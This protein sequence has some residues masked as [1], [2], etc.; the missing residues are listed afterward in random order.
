MNRA[1][2]L[3]TGLVLT[4]VAGY[5][6][7]IGFVRL[8]GLY[9]SFMSGNTTQ[10]SVLLGHGRP[11]HALL[12]VLLVLAFLTGA[13][14][15]SGLAILVPKRWATPAV[16]AYEALLILGALAL[17][18]ATPELELAAIFMALAMGTQNAVLGQV[19][20]FRAGTTFV[21][22]ALFSLGQKIAQALT[23][24]GRPLGWVGDAAVWLALLVGALAGTVA[25]GALDLYALTIPAAVAGLFAAVAG[26]LSARGG[27]GAL[28]PPAAPS[29]SPKVPSA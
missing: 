1:W 23:G 24:T 16:L 21:T 5:V 6:D 12:P 17:G 19:Q 8:G 9:T 14:L 25:Y 10:L 11:G 18:L 7:A 2:Q 22:G 15:G 4:G 20:G 3:G 27:V 28:A 13:T 29:P 26:I